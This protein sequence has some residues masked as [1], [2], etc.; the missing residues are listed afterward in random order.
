MTTMTMMRGPRQLHRRGYRRAAAGS[1][2]LALV[3]LTYS[4][5]VAA[6]RPSSAH[7]G[8]PGIGKIDHVVF[9]IKE[10]RSFDHYFGRYP[11]VDGATSGRLASGEVAPLR[12]ASDQ[13]WPDIA[14]ASDASYMAYDRGR[15]D[16]FDQLAGAVTLG[17]DDAYTQ[18]SA[19]DIPAYWAYAH[20]FTLDDHFFST[21]MG[22]TFPNHLVTIAAQSGNVVSNPQ[23]SGGRW[24]CDSLAGSFVLTKDP[25]GRAGAAA[26]CFD[27]A[28]LA[29][30]LNA[31]HIGWRYYAPPIGRPGY[32]FSTFDSIRHVRF[33]DQ[34]A[35]NVV[36]WTRFQADVT[37]GHLAA[38]TWLV[39]DTAESEHPP[40]STCLGENTTVSEINALMRSPFWKSTAIVVTWDDFGG[41]YDHVAPPQR[42][43]GGFGPRVPALVISPYARRGY[44]DHTP[45]NFASLLRFVETRF[46][47]PPLT[48]RDAGG[49]TLAASFDFAAPASPPFLQ[50]PHACP[51]IPGVTIN[52]NESG[53][54]AT[55][56]IDLTGAPHLTAL[57]RH[58]GAITVTAQSPAGV[59]TYGI[60]SGT[61]VLGRGGRALDRGALGVGDM[62][63]HQGATVQD[64]S[65]DTVT[66]GGRVV[67]S[68]MARGVVTL[69]VRTIPPPG[70]P[71]KAVRQQ[72][73]RVLLTPHT[74]V[75]M[76]GAGI[77]VGQSV[78]AT[79]ALNWRTATLMLTTRV[80]VR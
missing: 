24:G 27:F 72:V 19:R 21:V 35:T 54:R 16:A 33:G 52:G 51:I 8:L 43:P 64:E 34:W 78:W 47:L 76:R 7:A 18:M 59:E 22:P 31:R 9:I 36:P 40:A 53:S 30:R 63:Y 38:V 25:G 70:A 6:P 65:A 79:G 67:R 48:G 58:G 66:V 44:V 57:A 73:V 4:G 15:M 32:I 69:R 77:R 68:D 39:T 17:V 74:A 80:T 10:N 41:F 61:R 37:R 13:V 3:A 50:A 26:P 11:G 60:T 12:E 56:V 14:H 75:R 2:V 20:H 1:A 42:A 23:L 29:D 71:P 28:T 5:M 55:N 46:T 45:Y 62:V 49:P